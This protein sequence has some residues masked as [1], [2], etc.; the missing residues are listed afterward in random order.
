MVHLTATSLLPLLPL[1]LPAA[2]ANGMYS[3]ASPV[4]SLDG[5]TYRDE[6]AN[7]NHTALVEFYAPWCGHCKNLKPAYEKA[8][9]SL[10]GLAKVA[11][12]NCDAEEN[13][14]FCGSMGVQGFP[15]L[16]IVR[17][18]KKPGRP[19]VED[20]QGARNAKAMVDAV[21]DKI[22]N[23]VQRL[24]DAD[25]K[26]W[27]GEGE[28]PKAV[29]F[30]DKGT[31]SALLKALAVDFLG[32]LDVA[33]VRNREKEAVAAYNVDKFPT[34]V[35]FPGVGKEA[36]HYDGDMKKEAI[37][38]FLSQAASP[39]PD[40][41][42][43]KDKPK[44]PSS[45]DKAKSSKAASSF[46]KASSSHASSEAPAPQSA[47][48]LE[49]A[50][51]PTASPDPNVVDP[52]TPKPIAVPSKPIKSLPDALALQQSCLNTHARTCLLALLPNEPSASQ[53]DLVSSL[54]TLYD[55]HTRLPP[56]YHIPAGNTLTETLR[57][58][59]NLHPTEPQIL[60]L[61]A[62]RSWFSPFTSDSETP[63]QDW[64]NALRMG[65]LPKNPIPEGLV[66]DS[67][68][69]PPMEPEPET[70]SE[71]EPVHLNLDDLGDLPEGMEMVM[72][73][74]DDEEYERLMRG[75]GQGQ[76]HDEL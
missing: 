11:A 12:V 14:P 8:A 62:K 49:D 52:D 40:P 35:L 69:L 27:V 22:P 16:K 71:P 5:R 59:F 36:V 26:A 63:L 60:A 31:V 65:D 4:L 61:N 25:Y 2:L 6:V 15:T 64:L 48:T 29:L 43:K 18:G 41:A 28:A 57:K 68:T 23:H 32:V 76:G 33:Q 54:T 67:E 13:K 45:K 66:V 73:E 46:S 72:E 20:Y 30:S 74:V 70:E 51:Q 42:P 24:K 19:V 53:P 7:S 47:E 9:T 3:K 21:V 50:T 55:T 75:Q 38:K 56:L 39:N 17:P 10:K 58:D 34:L 44:T 1:L 37:V